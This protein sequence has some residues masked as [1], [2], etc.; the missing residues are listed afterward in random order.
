MSDIEEFVFFWGGKFSQWYKADMVIYGVKYNCCEQ[1]MMAEKA[2]LFEDDEIESKIME[3]K[4]PKE[5]KAL[6]RKVKNFDPE[7]WDSVARDVVYEGNY[8][9][10]NQNKDCLEEL[11]Q[12]GEKTIVEASPYDKIWGIGLAGDDPRAAN[13]ST[14]RG[15]NWLGIAIMKAR[16]NLK[17]G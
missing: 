3:S 8:A 16:E 7:R 2:R 10:F 1:Y 14:W 17:L 12:T 5:Q 15:T 4:N 9:K 6:G 11:F 13:R